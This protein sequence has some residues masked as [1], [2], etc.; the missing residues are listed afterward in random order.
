M[1]ASSD[2]VNMLP[3]IDNE[4]ALQAVKNTLEVREEQISPTLCIIEALEFCLKCNNSIFHKEH[5]LQTDRTVQDSVL[6]MQ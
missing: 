4:S 5:F 3:S 6:I 2:I 1:L